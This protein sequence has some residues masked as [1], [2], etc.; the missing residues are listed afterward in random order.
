MPLPKPLGV[1]AC[2]DICGQQ[3][4]DACRSVGLAV[5]DEVAVLG[6]DNDELLCELSSPG[7][8]S[9]I[10]DTHRT[11]YEAAALLARMMQGERLEAF[12]LRI[13][14][15]GVQRRL[16]TD[17][18]AIDD[19]LVVRAVRYIRDHACAPIN[20]Q[21]VLR[22]VPLSRKGLEARFR[23]LLNRTV[24]DEI[25]RVKLDRVKQLL[26]DTD[27]KVSDI[28]SRTGFEH[29]EYLSVAFKRE[30]GSTPG[31][32]RMQQASG[33]QRVITQAPRRVRSAAAPPPLRDNSSPGK[34]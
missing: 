30:T 20:V 22:V 4:L 7:L 19:P 18:L 2:Y 8:S 11:G 3:V 14:P 24:H 15:L 17:V 33:A 21:D 23:N 31:R 5:P 27:L 1:F 28:A 6:V 13:T 16:S 9:V 34:T 12:E 26:A 29:T 10:P 25:L 32:Y